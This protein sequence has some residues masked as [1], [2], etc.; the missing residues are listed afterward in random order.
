MK[1]WLIPSTAEGPATPAVAPA[2][3]VEKMAIPIVPPI[4]WPVNWPRD[5]T[6]LVLA[7]AGEDRDGD[8]DHGDAKAN[9]GDQHSGQHVS[10]VAAAGADLGEKGHADRRYSECR[11]QRCPHAMTSDQVAGHVRADACRKGKR[12]EREAGH[13]GARAE[14]VL[15]VDRAEEEQPEDRP[16]P[17]AGDLAD[18]DRQAVRR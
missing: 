9:A 3:M 13:E 6:R 1:A 2:A 4:S 15:E 18:R 11:G 12:D 8:R 7:G 5:H 16:C 17:R 14:D 10:E